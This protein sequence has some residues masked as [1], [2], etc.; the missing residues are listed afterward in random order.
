MYTGNPHRDQRNLDRRG[1]K[2]FTSGWKDGWNDLKNDNIRDWQGPMNPGGTIVNPEGGW[3]GKPFPKGQET[4]YYPQVAE[5]TQEQM[6]FMGS[7][8]NSPDFRKKKD[9]WDM[10]KDMEKK[11]F[12][13]FGAQE[14]TTQQEFNDYYNKLKQGESGNWLAMAKKKKGPLATVPGSVVAPNVPEHTG[15]SDDLFKQDPLRSYSSG[16]RYN[17]YGLQPL[18][19]G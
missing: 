5:L 1:H 16:Y 18:Y 10:T 12:W 17:N 13:G 4:T 11:G 14:P 15:F 6:D 3:G 8:Y 7:P 2:S 9:L 19:F